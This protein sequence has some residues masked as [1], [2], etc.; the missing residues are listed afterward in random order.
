[1]QFVLPV[2]LLSLVFSI[3]K[4]FETR[5]EYKTK[6]KEE[7]EFLSNKTESDENVIGEE[8]VPYTYVIT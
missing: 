3:P 6:E 1:M 2:S 5:V 8:Q 7:E 4:F